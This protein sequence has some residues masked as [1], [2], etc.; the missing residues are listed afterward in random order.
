MHIKL[1]EKTAGRLRANL[2]ALGFCDVGVVTAIG[3]L[4][5]EGSDDIDAIVDAIFVGEGFA[6]PDLADRHLRRAV[7]DAVVAAAN[8]SEA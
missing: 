6:E 7:R 5:S 3:A 8:D 1:N 2:S 4:V